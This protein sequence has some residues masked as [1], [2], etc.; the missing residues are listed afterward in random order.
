[1]PL[2]CKLRK[3]PKSSFSVKDLDSPMKFG[4]Y[5][6]SIFP[7]VKGYGESHWVVGCYVD[8]DYDKILKKISEEEMISAIMEHLNKV[9]PRRKF[10]RRPTSS[11]YGKL[12]LLSYKLKKAE[13]KPFIEL[14]LITDDSKNEN[15]W[16]EGINFDHG[17]K[18]RKSSENKKVLRR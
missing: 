9:P 14:L 15:F 18:R 4:R 7:Q 17:R 10:E 3:I 5:M 2:E 6:K 13:D 16:G 1:M 8:L 11:L 12:E